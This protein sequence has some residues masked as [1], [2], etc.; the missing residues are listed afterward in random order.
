M[1]ARKVLGGLLLTAGTVMLTSGVLPAISSAETAPAVAPYALEATA[2]VENLPWTVPD[3]PNKGCDPNR[4]GWHFVMNG[5]T[6]T[7]APNLLNAGDFGAIVISFSDGTSGTA[8]WQEM[9]G[10]TAH[11][12]GTADHQYG[13]V[14]PVSASM[15][16]PQGTRVTG[17]NNFVLSHPPCTFGST[18]TTTA[19]TT[20][21]TTTTTTTAPTTTTSTATTTT[22]APTTTT[23]TTTTTVAQST[24]TIPTTTTIVASQGGVPTTTTTT[25]VASSGA[26][27]ST[28][29]ASQ[30]LVVL[31]MVC[32]VLGG[33]TLLLGRR[34]SAS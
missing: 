27:P 34:P 24:P 33:L 21:T 2:T 30:T 11:F 7:V 31:G 13:T 6:A 29:Q 16:W 20:T 14:S 17:Y 10:Q 22:T 28:G 15:A 12:L 9:S 4:D 8:L 26:L 3:P 18:T 32:V 1:V 23:T 5:I 19:P 25:V